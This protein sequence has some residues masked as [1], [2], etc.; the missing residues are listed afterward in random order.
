[1]RAMDAIHHDRCAKLTC[2]ADDSVETEGAEVAARLLRKIF[3]PDDVVDFASPILLHSLSEP[4][5][6][7]AVP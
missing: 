3:V 2:G 4:C 7:V 1:M 5:R 6:G